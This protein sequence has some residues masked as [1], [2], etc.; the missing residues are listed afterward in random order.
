MNDVQSTVS[1]M[2]AL[3]RSVCFVALALLFACATNTDPNKSTAS[4]WVGRSQ[5]DLIAAWGQPSFTG[6]DEQGG[7]ILTYQSGVSMGTKNGQSEPNGLG[8]D[9]PTGQR[10]LVKEKSRT[11]YVNGRGMIYQAK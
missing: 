8:M 2:K 4:S 5:A 3:V 1:N 10:G 6:S 9:S 11:F 7:N